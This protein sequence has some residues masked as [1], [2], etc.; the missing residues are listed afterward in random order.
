MP[1]GLVSGYPRAETSLI[2][3]DTAYT[4]DFARCSGQR[5]RVRSARRP[6]G[7]ERSALLQQ[8]DCCALCAC[9]VLFLS[10]DRSRH[11]PRLCSVP[12][13]EGISFSPLQL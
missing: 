8:S 2:R 7:V 3:R 9:S 13:L 4:C 5:V 10:S 6:T 1:I 12:R 11:P